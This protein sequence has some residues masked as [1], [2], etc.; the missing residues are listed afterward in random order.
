MDDQQQI[1]NQLAY[2]TEK[3]EWLL[4]RAEGGRPKGQ[5]FDDPR[6]LLVRTHLSIIGGKKAYPYYDKN[7]VESKRYPTVDDIQKSLAA[8]A[9]FI[10]SKV[11]N[12]KKVAT[13]VE[14]DIDTDD[15]GQERRDFTFDFDL[16]ADSTGDSA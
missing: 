13:V 16:E 14:T 9:P 3:V 15:E 7:G 1:N 11:A 12:S 2:L 10:A 4:K 6:A 5:G 8:I